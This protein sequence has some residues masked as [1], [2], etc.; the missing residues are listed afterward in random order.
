MDTMSTDPEERTS[1]NIHHFPTYLGVTSVNHPIEL[2]DG[3]TRVLT[4]IE[5]WTNGSRARYVEINTRRSRDNVRPPWIVS[6]EFGSVFDTRM[7]GFGGRF[8]W[9]HGAVWI[10]PVPLRN[11]SSITLKSVDVEGDIIIA[12]V[13]HS[14]T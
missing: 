7:D 9:I 2:P 6:D 14:S 13:V 8:G 11:V 1:S 12:Q 3:S 10:H 5:F 4:L